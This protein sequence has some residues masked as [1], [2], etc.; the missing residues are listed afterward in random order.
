MAAS[1]SPSP[2]TCGSPPA[3]RASPCPRS[4]SACFPAGGGTQRLTALVGPS[5]ARR[6]ILGGENIDGVEAQRLGVVQWVIPAAELATWSA[7]LAARLG[8]NPRAAFAA[9]KRC[10]ALAEGGF[11][12]GFAEEIA[13]TRAL[14]ADPQTLERVSAFLNRP[15]PAR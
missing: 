9:N 14:Y 13:A 1:S 10:V 7:Q 11:A 15:K 5:V 12:A 3:R 4:A 8:G 2:A 6:L